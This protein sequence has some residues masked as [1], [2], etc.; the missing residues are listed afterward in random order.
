[1][2]IDGV[3]YCSSLL[4]VVLIAM[5]R[6]VQAPDGMIFVVDWPWYCAFEI[7]CLF[8][9]VNFLQVGYVAEMAHIH[10]CN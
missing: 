8:L 4:L 6:E 3:F 10:G 2:C 1:M 9:P 5:S 7:S